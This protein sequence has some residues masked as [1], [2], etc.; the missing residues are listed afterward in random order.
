[1]NN[2]QGNEPLFPDPPGCSG[3]RL[4][5]MLRDA[6]FRGDGGSITSQEYLAAFDRINLC[7]TSRW[8]RAAAKRMAP[9]VLELMRGRGTLLLGRTVTQCLGFG[10][11]P[12]MFANALT[13]NDKTD[14]FWISV[15]HPSGMTREYNAVEFRR[16]VGGILFALYQKSVEQVG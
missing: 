6:S 10:S 2:P 11:P 14:G 7:P 4:W 8:D 9:T 12:W 3:W 13:V 15:P 16:K 1:M 5:Q